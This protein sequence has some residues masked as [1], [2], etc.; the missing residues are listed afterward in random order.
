MRSQFGGI[1]LEQGS[2]FGGVPVAQPI[3]PVQPQGFAGAGIIEPALTIGSGAIAEPIAGLAGIAQ[4]INPLAEEGAGARAVEA[5]RE[6][7]TFQPRTQAGQ[8][9]LQSVGEALRPVGEAISGT[10]KF[11]GDTVFEATDSPALASAAAS[12]PTAILETIGLK[13]SGRIA[14]STKAVQPS[15][16]AIRKSLTEAAPEPE[17]LK[18]LSRQIYT[19]LDDSGVRLKPTAYRAAVT[20]IKEAARKQ[21]LSKRTTARS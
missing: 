16:R 15:Q 9:G 17:Q 21:G 3:P 6:A 18:N 4:S 20:K 19:E 11:L 7:L 13:G 12:L 5:T 8:Q 14:K 2:R 10:E 1:P